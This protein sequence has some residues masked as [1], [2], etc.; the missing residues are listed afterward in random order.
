[1]TEPRRNSSGRAQAVDA[2]DRGDDDDILARDQRG[3]GGQA[4]ALDF[5][6]N[7]GL[8]FDVQVVARDVGLGLVVI[9]VRDEVL[10]RVFGEEILELGIQLGGQ[11]LVVRHD[12]G[13]HLQALDDRSHRKGLAGS[14]GA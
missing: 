12:Q 13:R 10:D 9:V 8:F 14:G 4:Q 11:G 7:L 6:V 3:G 1:L 5:L 2:R